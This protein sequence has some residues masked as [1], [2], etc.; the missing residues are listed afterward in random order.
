MRKRM[1]VLVI[2]GRI[3]PVVPGLTLP[4]IPGLTGNLK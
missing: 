1:L 2:P 4:V 3:I